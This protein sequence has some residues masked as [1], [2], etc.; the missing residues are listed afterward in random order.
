MADEKKQPQTWKLIE[1]TGS[2]WTAMCM[3]VN[4]AKILMEAMLPH[5][6]DN[7]AL[8]RL[9]TESIA[10]LKRELARS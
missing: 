2:R 10:G 1:E 5:V 9:A 7:K 6:K 4:N 8:V 3:E